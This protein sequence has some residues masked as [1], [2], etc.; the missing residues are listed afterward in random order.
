[1][2]RRPQRQPG[3]LVRVRRQ[4]RFAHEVPPGWDGRLGVVLGYEDGMYALWLEGC[5]ADGARWF[6]RSELEAA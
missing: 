5:E 1:M 2:T 6:F 4:K 3:T